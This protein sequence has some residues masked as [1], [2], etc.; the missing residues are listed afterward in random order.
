LKFGH[1]VALFANLQN[2]GTRVGRHG[3]S[4]QRDSDQMVEWR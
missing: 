1:D 2:R 4:E 3:G